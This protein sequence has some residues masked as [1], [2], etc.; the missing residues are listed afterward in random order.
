MSLVPHTR[1]I[2]LSNMK[3]N[4]LAL[5][6]V[7]MLGA[8]VGLPAYAQSG[9]VT[10]GQ[11]DE[12]QAAPAPA[13]NNTTQSGG[14]TTEQ[15]K[16]TATEHGDWVVHCLEEQT[17]AEKAAHMPACQS[18]QSISVEGQKQPIAQVA[19]GHI[20]DQNTLTVTAIVPSNISLPG[21]VHISGNGETEA[22]EK[23]GVDLTWR[24]C[25][26]GLCYATADLP[27]DVLDVM[28]AGSKGALFFQDAT[29]RMIKLPLSWNG[30][31][32]A[33]DSL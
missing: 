23:G 9:D 12:S 25:L 16:T 3:R 31:T 13:E 20:K 19:L 22:A 18:V 24:R 30:F 10:T 11:S 7:L 4:T 5:V 8:S 15:P 6:T 29:G 14:N 1:F 17:D 28:K 33:I 2:S 26:G 21:K 27:A 32:A